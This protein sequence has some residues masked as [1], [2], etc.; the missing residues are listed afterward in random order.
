MRNV[1]RKIEE[2]WQGDALEALAEFVRLPAKSPDF[3]PDWE[4]NGVLLRALEDAA[5]WAKVRFPEGTF[6]ILSAPGVTP[7]LWVDI[8]GTRPG[9]PALF[10]GHFDKQPEA[11]EWSEGLAQIGRAHV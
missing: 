2:A 3:D 6:E 11:G 5:R 4:Q 7:V 1:F 10:Y 9:R 8:P